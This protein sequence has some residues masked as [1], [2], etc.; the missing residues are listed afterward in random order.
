[1][2]TIKKSPTADSRCCDA[3]NISKETLRASTV[4]HQQDVDAAMNFFVRKLHFAA[5]NHDEHKLDALDAFH[6]AFTGGFI[7]ETWWNEHKKERHHLPENLE[8]VNL[9]DVLEHISDCV[10]AGMARTGKVRPLTIGNDM[11]QKAFQNT[12][13][14]LVNNVKVE[15]G[16]PRSSGHMS[17]DELDAAI[18][19]LNKPDRA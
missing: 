6:K 3:K 5:I 11:L 10:V 9:I 4:Q 2:I 18:A 12:V 15:S 7:D 8:D 13:N 14:L 1:M 17:L 19:A 16:M